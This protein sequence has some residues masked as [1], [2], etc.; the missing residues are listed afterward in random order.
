MVTPYRFWN[1]PSFEDENRRRHRRRWRKLYFDVK[2]QLAGGKPQSPMPPAG[3]N[4]S[5]KLPECEYTKSGSATL[6]N[7]IIIGQ[8]RKVDFRQ[9]SRKSTFSVKAEWSEKPL[10]T[11]SN[12]PCQQKQF[13]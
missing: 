9:C 2:I 7:P 5:A 10:T 13:L 3:G 8:F 11:L 12:L 1:T 4:F 6:P